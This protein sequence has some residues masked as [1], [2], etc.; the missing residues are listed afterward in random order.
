MGKEDAYALAIQHAG[1]PKWIKII[2]EKMV[3]PE[4]VKVLEDI[5]EYLGLNLKGA[6]NWA[7]IP[8]FDLYDSKVHGFSVEVE[9]APHQ[10][11]AD[12]CDDFD[13]FQCL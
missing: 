4:K 5:K 13:G 2:G 11:L 6:T 9:H 12:A 7:V 10:R 1:A 3:H 8:S